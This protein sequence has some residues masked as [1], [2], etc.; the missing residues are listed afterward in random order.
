VQ[1]YVSSI[2]ERESQGP[3]LTH[4]RFVGIEPASRA[5]VRRDPVFRP[6]TWRQPAGH[7]ERRVGVGAREFVA[8]DPFLAW[9]LARAGIDSRA[10][11]VGALQRRLPACLRQLRVSS[12][13]AARALIESKPELL[14]QA[15]STILIG[16]SEFF[17]DHE[18]FK[19]LQTTFL[20]EL[21]RKRAFL[22]VCAAGVS[23][24]QELYSVAM[25]LAEAGALNGS[26]LLGIDLRA[27]AIASARTGRFDDREV[28]RLAPAFREQ[29]FRP[30][31][32]NWMVRDELR[33]NTNWRVADL[34]AHSASGPWDLIVFRNVA[35]YFDPARGGMV[36]ERLCSELRPGGVLVCG[37]AENPPESLPFRRV[38]PCIYQKTDRI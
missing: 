15:L 29:Y 31:G 3:D 26:Y 34:F 32:A 21:L 4:V 8:L 33:A 17:R 38:A 14:P 19:R 23:T 7:G 5:R 28:N 12:V 13:E 11:R 6:G 18:V 16:V 9:L 30:D 1:G 2:Y 25:L 27:D 37:K 22:R 24:G 35:I 10:Y 36:W 20:P